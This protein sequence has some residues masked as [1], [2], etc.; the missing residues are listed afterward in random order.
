MV[1]STDSFREPL[2]RTINSNGNILSTYSTEPLP[3][4]YTMLPERPLPY[5]GDENSRPTEGTE[6]KRQTE[7][8]PFQPIIRDDSPSP[9]HDGS[10]NQS[11]CRL[12][13]RFHVEPPLRPAVLDSEAWK[14]G[15]VPIDGQRQSNGVSDAESEDTTHEN[16]NENRPEKITSCD[17]SEMPS[18]ECL[19]EE[20]AMIV[21]HPLQTPKH[22]HS[23]TPSSTN[24]SSSTHSGTKAGQIA[25]LTHRPSRVSL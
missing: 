3:P 9:S 23:Q 22:Y 12:C 10:N 11:L 25:T 13:R 7:P 16:D 21:S 17:R 19:T 5:I 1:S 4:P 18:D 8:R 6:Q 14:T 24:P 2:C 20:L 15:M